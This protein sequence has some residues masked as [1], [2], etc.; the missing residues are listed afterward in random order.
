M[1]KYSTFGYIIFLMYLSLLAVG[2]LFYQQQTVIEFEKI[3][4]ATIV[5]EASD[6]ALLE[7]VTNENMT[8]DQ[9]IINPKFCSDTFFRIFL[10]SYEMSLSEENIVK[11]YDYVPLLSLVCNDG[12]YLGYPR[13][14][15]G[16][17]Y[18]F[19]WEPKIPYVYDD[20]PNNPN[21]GRVQ[22]MTINGMGRSQINKAT[23]EFT[24]VLSEIVEPTNKNKLINDTIT[25]ALTMAIS[26]VNEMN[27]S[28]K[29]K[30]FVPS[31]LTDY[32]VVNFHG[33][34]LMAFVQNVDINTKEKLNYFSIGGTQ[35]T[36]ANKV[37]CYVDAGRRFYCF[38]SN[39]TSNTEVNIIKVFDNVW[40]AAAQGYEPD[41]RRI[42]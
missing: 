42:K 4:L 14:V 8:L 35:A 40:Q 12:I 39:L 29:H 15:D 1:G 30:F 36:R 17:K 20:S 33:T 3:R 18:E 7:A 32:T 19:Y 16:K 24:D 37:V 34:T 13:L 2:I 41:L 23:G 22:Y 6:S 27:S 28:W 5:N 31:D 10:T 21:G 26:N 25:N 38:S 11:C 9:A